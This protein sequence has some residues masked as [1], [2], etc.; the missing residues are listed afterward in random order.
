MVA[1]P[2]AAARE[3]GAGRV[4]VVDAPDRARSRACSPT[5]SR[6]RSR[7]CPTAPAAPS[8]RRSATIP[9]GA[10]VVVL[11]GDVPLVSPDV[12]R[13]ARRR[14]RRVAARRRRWSRRSS[15][16]PPATA[17]SCATPT[18]RFERV[19][20]TKAPGDATDDEL[21]IRGGQHRH[22]R[23]RRAPRSRPRCRSVG[24]RQRPGRAL[25][26]RRPAAAARRRRAGRRA[27]RRRPELVLGVNDRVDLAR[28]R[29]DRPAPDH[30]A[31]TCA[32]A[33]TIVDPA[34]TLIDAGVEIGQDTVDRAVHD[35]ARRDDASAAAAG[36]ARLDADR[37]GV[38]DECT[39]LHAYLD[40]RDVRRR[41]QRRPVRLPA[42]GHASCASGS[43]AGTFVEIKNS[44][45][46]EGTKVPH[47]SYI[48]DADVGEG[49]NLGA[50]TITANYDGRNKHRTTIGAGVQRQR[51]HVA[52]SRRSRSATAP[53]RRPGRVITEDVPPGALGVARARQ[54]EHRGLRRA[55]ARRPSSEART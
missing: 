18:A 31:S 25:P 33:S 47:L 17:A 29:G 36:S 28:V 41:R 10:P 45:I 3:A 24:D 2:V 1:W 9:D 44:D 35:P 51:R 49:T 14:A 26:A 7:R 50:G 15:T 30:R 43:K 12:D 53:G 6:S 42:P 5:A 40:R 48:G 13:R 52:S 39:V 20:E 32:P 46:G 11:S 34:S 38:G 22:L 27:R 8:P 37:R 19:V 21:A 4:V 54:D 16:T 23:L 55:R